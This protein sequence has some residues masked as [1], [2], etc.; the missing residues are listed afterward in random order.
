V[1][2]QEKHAMVGK[3][4]SG[5]WIWEKQMA[6]VMVQ[7]ANSIEQRAERERLIQPLLL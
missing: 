3:E 1:N 6:K 4:Q 2:G 5:F 7:G